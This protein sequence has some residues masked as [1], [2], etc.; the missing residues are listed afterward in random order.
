MAMTKPNWIIRPDQIKNLQGED[1]QLFCQELLDFEAQHRHSGARV[2]GPPAKYVGDKG[3]DLSVEVTA[4]PIMLRKDFPHSLIQDDVVTSCVSCKTGSNWKDLLKKDAGKPAPLE[5]LR[6]G[7]QFLMLVGTDVGETDTRDLHK[8]VCGIV[9][10]RL[11]ANQ[12]DLDNRVHLYDA[13]DLASFYTYHPIG[14]D[15]RTRVILGVSIPSGLLTFEEWRTFLEKARWLPSFVSDTAREKA[16]E[17][18]L[19]LLQAR[20]P[21]SK[22]QGVWILG[23]P[24]VGKSRLALESIIRASG[25]AQRVLIAT[26]FDQGRRAIL[27]SSVPSY[28]DVILVVDECPPPY[29]NELYASF[30]AKTGGSNGTLILVGPQEGPSQSSSPAIPILAVAPLEMSA[31]RALVEQELSIGS[32]RPDL[33]QRVLKLVEGYPWFAVL[34]AR[35]IRD[36]LTLLPDGA[37]QLS[38]A[39]LAIAGPPAE[40]GGSLDQWNKAFLLRAKALLAVILTADI[41]WATLSDEGE[42]RLAGALQAS[43]PDI[44][45]AAEACWNRGILRTRQGWKYKYVTPR[46]LARLVATLLLGD[47][48]R[49]DKSIRASVPHLRPTLYARLEQLEV[50]RELLEE[51]AR[52]EAEDEKPFFSLDS[53]LS[54]P[55]NFAP[56]QF[57]AKWQ[58][59][60]TAY[61][62]RSLVD[63]LTLDELRKRADVR[64]DLVFALAHIA[65]RKQGFEDAEA[66]LFRLALAENESWSNNATGVWA[67]LF[68]VVLSLTHRPFD[69][70]LAILRQ[71]T[72]N[73]DVL[74]RLF[75]L[76]GLKSALSSEAAGP[77]YSDSDTIDGPWPRP[78]MND[79]TQSKANAWEL[80]GELIL[81]PEPLVAAAARRIAIEAFRTAVRWRAGGIAVD[82]MKESSSKWD[83]ES[84][85]KLR[86]EINLVKAYDR[87][88]LDKVPELDAAI[89]ELNKLI[90][91]KSYHERLLQVVGQWDPAG[92]SVDVGGRPDLE[93]KLDE[94][95]AREGLSQP[96]PVLSE[97][98]W[99]ETEGAVRAAQFMFQLGAIDS[100]RSLL[101]ALVERAG[102]IRSNQNLSLY[103]VG[104]SSSEPEANVDAIIRAWRGETRL[105]PVTL[106]TV[107]RLAATD[108]RTGWIV[109]DLETGRV[110]PKSIPH[111]SFASW[112]TGGGS[113]ALRRLIETLAKSEESVALLAAL[114]TVI[115][116]T[117]AKPE[118]MQILEPMLLT[119]IAQLASKPLTGMAAYTWKLGCELALSR[120]HV[121]TV[122][123]AA[124][125]AIR[126][127]ERYGSDDD[128]WGVLI[129]AAK[130]S[131]EIVWHSITP[132]FES[133]EAGSYR[134]LVEASSHHLMSQLP[135]GVVLDWVSHDQVRSI[136]VARMCSAHEAPLNEIARQLIIRFGAESD[137][138]RELAA[139]AYSTPEAVWG[140]FSAFF[141]TQADRALNWAN[142]PDPIVAQWGKAR[143]KEFQTE[144]ERESAR[145]EFENEHR[146]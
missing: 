111:L 67:D 1:F 10:E 60:L 102:T 19:S 81:D 2:G 48:H 9:A 68:L 86:I 93:R 22:T 138:G 136:I 79:I 88:Q 59:A 63:S 84:L 132:A 72:T 41:D 85:M 4:P 80:L 135:P 106:L 125:A 75:A 29:V 77:M 92:P 33:V 54:G 105:A 124:V 39:R 56:L 116:R 122:A 35:A 139:R 14:L 137:A 103:V 83:E 126:A 13:D 141:K 21:G 142:D 12:K 109:D 52:A 112:A 98:N 119:L 28:A 117:R 145:E 65:R 45:Q 50:R 120:G 66:A 110:D 23:P 133:K 17:G 64:R 100:G 8:D 90:A 16:L 107:T 99:L 108:E 43:W 89:S 128:A 15:D 25:A 46:N 82:I 20:L 127:T 144:F 40:Y 38:A 37:D 118:E 57:L 24:G 5:T 130:K 104:I 74:D 140:P 7:G 131:P 31:A 71:R 61:R 76:T 18:L 6:D 129:D 36:D 115:D 123:D 26:G 44:K 73:G 114:D 70:R 58:P 51:L 78:T 96:Y 55:P 30:N 134:I 53:L 69:Q 42:K 121:K 97:L 11:K 87:V 94:E 49:L 3:M 143:L 95:L 113:G 101:Q 34:L 27:E 91:P 146:M 32:D 47:P 62:L